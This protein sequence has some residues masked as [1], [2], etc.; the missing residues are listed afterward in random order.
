MRDT[1][2]LRRHARLFTDMAEANGVDLEEAVLRGQLDPDDIA[3]GV[4]KCTGCE[5]PGDCEAALAAGKVTDGPP[6]YCKNG[7][8]LSALK[9]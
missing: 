7:G 3:D 1:K 9:P 6:S 4:L 8:M 2:T 5:N